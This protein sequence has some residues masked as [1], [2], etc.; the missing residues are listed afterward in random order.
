MIQLQE[1]L[2]FALLFSILLHMSHLPL[3]L[4]SNEPG[5]TTT[6]LQLSYRSLHTNVYGHFIG[7]CIFECAYCLVKL[8][9]GCGLVYM[10]LKHKGA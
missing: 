3:P 6:A 10:N 1:S 9:V 8:A 5:R 7:Q 4:K 2:T